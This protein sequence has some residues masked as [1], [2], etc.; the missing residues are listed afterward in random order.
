MGD[1]RQTISLEGEFDC[2]RFFLRLGVTSRMSNLR[3]PA[4]GLAG[5]DHFWRLSGCQEMFSNDNA[6]VHNAGTAARR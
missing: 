6:L 4:A 2:R 5:R 1:S 3:A